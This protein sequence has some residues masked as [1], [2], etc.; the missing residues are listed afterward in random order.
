MRTN[1]RILLFCFGL[2]LS[3][4]LSAQYIP[5]ASS[6]GGSGDVVG[7]SSSVNGQLAIFSGANGKL[8]AAFTSSGILKATSGVVAA[9]VADTDYEAPHTTISGYGITDG[10]STS[11]TISTTSPLGGGGAL[12]GN[13]TFT[14][15]TCG[16]SANNL[17]FFS[18]TTSAQLAALLSD[19]TGTGAAVFGTSPTLVTPALGTPSAVVLTNATGLPISSGVSGLASGIA[20]FLASAAS[21]NLAA[22]ISD[23]TGS[24]SLVFNTSPSLVTPSLGVATATTINK[25]T[26][27][28]PAAGATLTIN[29]GTTLTVTN[30]ATESGTNTGDQTITA[31]G[32]VTSG[33]CTGTCVTTIAQG[34]VTDDKASLLN[35]PAAAFVATTNIGLSG[36]SAVDG[37]TPIDGTIVLAS[38]QTSGSQNGPWVAHSGSWTRPSWY[39]SGGTTQ[40]GQFST[41]LIRLGTESGHTWRMTTAAPI[42]ID[43]TATTWVVTPYN[44][45]AAAL[46]GT[47]PAAQEPAHTGDATNTAG[48]LAMTLKNTGAGAGSCTNCSATFDAQ[49]RETAYSSGTAGSA[50]STCTANVIQKGNGAN[51]LQDSGLTE[52]AAGTFRTAAGVPLD[53]APSVQT[54]DTATVNALLTGEMA[55]SQASTNTTGGPLILAGGLGAKKFT[56]VTFGSTG[57]KTVTLT[58]NNVSTTLTEGTDWTCVGTSNNTCASNLATAINANGTLGSKLT[59]TASSAVVGIDRKAG[60]NVYAL[61]LATNAGAPLTATNGTDGA[62]ALGTSLQLG[63]D[64]SLGGTYTITVP[65]KNLVITPGGTT[66]FSTNTAMS[67]NLSIAGSTLSAGGTTAMTMDDG[68]RAAE[69]LNIPLSGSG[70]NGAPASDAYLSGPPSTGTAAS[71]NLRLRTAPSG[72]SG[73]TLNTPITRHG[74]KAQGSA[75]TS[76]AAANVLDVTLPT[77]TMSGGTIDATI[78]ATDGTDMQSFHQIVEWS[79]VNKGASYTTNVTASAGSKSVSAGTLTTSWSV[80]NGTNKVTIQVTPTTSLTTTKFLLYYQVFSNGEQEVTLD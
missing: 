39:P 30:N 33:G 43:T 26:L 77:L 69:R 10:V 79:A 7:P 17:S 70:T 37:V 72:A 5:P 56:I 55:Y 67:G 28:Q 68:G 65:S 21:A 64:P 4:S 9:A 12:S 2:V 80:S 60:G 62:T 14:C 76:G 27:T 52:T 78:I 53:L 24:G 32:D 50:C 35:K 19:E 25:L 61:T 3:A 49:G 1:K 54:S 36:L 66:T 51:T 71:S 47:L 75:L 20:T 6:S 38:A 74:M 15:T 58:V 42:T 23:E 8:L 22:A 57:G 13:L 11:R 46:A 45:T 63:L 34:A 31:T 18:A 29:D 44:M 73:S 41:M 16:T 59:A 48:S 40:A